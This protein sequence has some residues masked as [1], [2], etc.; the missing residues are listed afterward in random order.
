MTFFRYC[1]IMYCV[2][3]SILGAMSVRRVDMNPKEDISIMKKLLAVI[4]AALV[5]A[6]AVACSDVGDDP[7]D[8]V[9]VN[10]DTQE[11]S[12]TDTATGD[13][14]TYEL[15]NSTSVKITDFSSSNFEPHT[16]TIPETIT[17]VTKKNN[18]SATAE[19]DMTVTVIGEQA[20]Y[21]AS[22]VSEIKFNKS[23]TTIETFAFANCK[24]LSS[25][26]LPAS[27]TEIGTGAF[28][29]C[30]TLTTVTMNDGLVTVGDSAFNSCTA[31]EQV[32][33]ASSIETIGVA[34]FSDCTALKEIVIPEG[35]KDIEKFAFYHCSAVE[36]VTL[37]ASVEHI[38]LYAFS[39]QLRG[40]EVETED[41]EVET[42]DVEFHT[43]D[44][45]YA[46]EY[47]K[48]PPSAEEEG[49]D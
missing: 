37:P 26:T 39:T 46:A 10:L 6:G 9:V 44:G 22:N 27:L 38:G 13:T 17:V 48:N 21:A 19:I 47:I 14:F 1:C 8:G 12:Y 20:F 25:L 43:V 29:G 3:S 41:G 7:N 15:L 4:L 31:L 34:A 33:F 32:N 11:L 24:T 36:S 23:L 18:S 45:S 16:V 35:V 2:E 40:R 49:D 30:D 5:L 42:V 28:Y